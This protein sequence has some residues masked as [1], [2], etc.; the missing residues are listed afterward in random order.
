MSKIWIILLVLAPLVV[1]SQQGQN[2]QVGAFNIEWFPCKDDGEMM[3]KY[4]INLRRPPEGNATNIPALFDLLKKMDIELLGVV[5]IVDPALLEESA[6]KYL[7]PQF[8]V[9]YAPCKG[10]Q[11]IGFLYDSSVLEVLG[12]PEVYAE[13][14]LDP[15]S[16][17][18]P[19]FRVYFKV[20]PNGMDFHAIITHLKASPG[21]WGKRERQWKVL[22]EILTKLPEQTGDKDIVLMGDFNNVSKLGYDEFKPVMERLGFL[23]ANSGMVDGKGYT[24]YWKPDYKTERIEGSLI[25]HIFISGDAQQEY[26][27]KSVRTGGM[28]TEAEQDFEGDEIP[29]Y[30]EQISDHCPIFATFRVDVDN[31]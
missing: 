5:E 22:E 16:W 17:L 21:G 28:C 24:N 15:N 7:G 23:W 13:V 19:A 1:F 11:K 31:D 12:Q 27:D 8:K 6:Q 18:R 4:D 3:K 30:Y 20:K 10:S 14:K 29:E 25:D 26:V 2:I 9:L